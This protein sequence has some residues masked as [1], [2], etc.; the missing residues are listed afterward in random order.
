MT[1]IKDPDATLDYYVDWTAWLA[2]DTIVA[3]TWC[4]MPSSLVVDSD[5]IIVG[6][7]KTVVWLSG[8][9]DGTTY[10]ATNHITT[11]TGREDDRS[12]T[13]AVEDK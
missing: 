12:I 11:A 13:I 8:G 3:S 6:L 2:G 1:F 9:V 7:Q 5:A 10:T 4:V